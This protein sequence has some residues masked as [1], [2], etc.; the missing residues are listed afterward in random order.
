MTAT[1][2]AP[3]AVLTADRRV[4]PFDFRDLS[5][6]IYPASVY[7]VWGIMPYLSR[8]MNG[9]EKLSFNHDERGVGGPGVANVKSVSSVERWNQARG[10][11]EAKLRPRESVSLFQP[12]RDQPTY[13]R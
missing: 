6:D 1:P 5:P 9:R 7:N 8:R 4:A 2:I 3:S 13:R 11:G 12:G 10:R